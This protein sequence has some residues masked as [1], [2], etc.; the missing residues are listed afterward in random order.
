MLDHTLQRDEPNKT[1]H[2][3]KCVQSLPKSL[4]FYFGWYDKI[5]NYVIFFDSSL[6]S[7]FDFGL[8]AFIAHII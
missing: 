7:K 1:L 8:N 6:K 4:T 2:L 3:W 5:Y